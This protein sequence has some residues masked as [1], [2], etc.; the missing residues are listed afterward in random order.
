MKKQY[1]GAFGLL[2]FISVM[3]SVLFPENEKKIILLG[4]IWGIMLLINL[5]LGILLRK[6]KIDN[7]YY[8]LYYG[9][10]W[11]IASFLSI[12]LIYSF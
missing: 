12:K 2:I 3:F 7:A 5:V 4:V 9:A 10:F 11:V 6:R 8:L 1:T